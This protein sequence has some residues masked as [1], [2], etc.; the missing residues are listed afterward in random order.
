MATAKSLSSWRRTGDDFGT[1]L[2]A[3]ILVRDFGV[4][5]VFYVG[6]SSCSSR[7]GRVLNVRSGRD[8]RKSRGG[9]PTSKSVTT[10]EWLMARSAVATMIVVAVLAGTANLVI[11]T[12][13]PALRTAVLGLDPANAVYVFAPSSLGLA[14]ALIV[15]GRD[16][17]DRRAA[18]RR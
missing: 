16:P 17:L 4:Y 2:L 11:Q 6:G 13:A 5:A 1:A 9:G 3:P 12:L 10:L 14:L 15:A 18:G 8:E 7:R